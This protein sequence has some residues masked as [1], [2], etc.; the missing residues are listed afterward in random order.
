[1]SMVARSTS[2][3]GLKLRP[4]NLDAWILL[5]RSLHKAIQAS[6]ADSRPA[7]Q[8][9]GLTHGIKKRRIYGRHQTGIPQTVRFM[10][11]T[12]LILR[13]VEKALRC[14]SSS[15]DEA[16]A[17][18][19]ADPS[20]PLVMDATTLTPPCMCVTLQLTVPIGWLVG[21]DE[22]S[23]MLAPPPSHSSR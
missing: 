10:M 22:G 7:S 16:S 9:R 3:Y 6:P 20:T 11:A 5:L 8:D 15:S 12:V 17:T 18:P 4:A 14:S 13:Y 19:F 2:S 21:V 1:M 23:D